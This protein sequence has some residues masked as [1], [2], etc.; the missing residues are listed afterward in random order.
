M[1]P[2]CGEIVPVKPKEPKFRVVILPGCRAAVQATP[3]QLQKWR[4]VLVSF[5]EDR[6]PSESLEMHALKAIKASRSVVF[7]GFMLASQ[8]ERKQNG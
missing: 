4:V 8:E 5:H 6:A 2:R 3:G 1:L 7:P